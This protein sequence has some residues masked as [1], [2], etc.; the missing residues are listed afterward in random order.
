M[1]S[2]SCK[3]YVEIESFEIFKQESCIESVSSYQNIKMDP[4][5]EILYS[6]LTTQSKWRSNIDKAFKNF[7]ST[8]ALF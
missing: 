2:N 5:D 6:W 8:Q 7:C 1:Q 3:E 4:M